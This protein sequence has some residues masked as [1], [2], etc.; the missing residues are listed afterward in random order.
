MKEKLL[1]FLRNNSQDYFT[2]DQLFIQFPGGFLK[3]SFI[4]RAIKKLEN[5]FEINRFNLE[6]HW[7]W[8][9]IWAFGYRK[10]Q[11]V[12]YSRAFVAKIGKIKR[13]DW[14]VLEKHYELDIFDEHNTYQFPENIT[15]QD[16]LW[17]AR[18]VDFNSE[19]RRLGLYNAEIPT[20]IKEWRT[21]KIIFYTIKKLCYN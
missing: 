13:A 9:P 14:K 12:W 17:R 19:A 8:P 3:R 15:M 6:K 20:G 5:K 21:G 7:S 10:K 18:V 2:L 4:K 1:L 11:E 16:I